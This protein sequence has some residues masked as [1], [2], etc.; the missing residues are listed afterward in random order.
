MIEN[1]S[2]YVLRLS[3]GSV[4]NQEISLKSTVLSL[5]LIKKIRL[6]YID[7]SRNSWLQEIP[8]PVL[9]PLV[10]KKHVLWHQQSV[11]WD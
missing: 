3:L 4:Y 7:C 1:V 9:A 5:K 6:F 10:G 2:V 8:N 11:R